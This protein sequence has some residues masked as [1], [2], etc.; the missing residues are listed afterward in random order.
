MMKE[1]KAAEQDMYSPSELSNYDNH[2]AELG[3]ELFQAEFNSALKVHEEHLLKDIKDA[4][5]RIDDNR[6]GKC[7][8]CGKDIGAERLEAIPYT[9]LCIDCEEEKAVTPEILRSTENITSRFSENAGRNGLHFQKPI[10]EVIFSPVLNKS[11]PVEELVQ[12]AP[13]GRKYLNKR[14]DDEHEGMD[15]FND[16]MKYGS[17]DS[18]QDLGGY[19]DYEE[20][21]TN[22]IDRQGIVDDMDSISNEEYKKQLPD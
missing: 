7:A 6:F 5:K 4:I 13:M 16:L 12:D 8:L 18:P 22:V 19:H 17:A 21:Y 3:T 20:Y 11:R 2:P 10:R 1:N 14:E 9:R 15:Q